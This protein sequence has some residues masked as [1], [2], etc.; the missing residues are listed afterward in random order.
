VSPDAI[1]IAS[2]QAGVATSANGGSATLRNVPVGAMEGV[3]ENY[4]CANCGCYE[5]FAGTS[6]A[7]PRWAGFMALVNQQAVEAG[8][9]PSGGIGF[10]NPPL[11]QLAPGAKCRQDFHGTVSCNNTA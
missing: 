11:Y 6:F 2:W 3:F 8:T 1:P 9:A 7:A 5:D 10:L 4:A